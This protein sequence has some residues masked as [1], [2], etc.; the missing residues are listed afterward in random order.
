[1]KKNTQLLHIMILVVCTP[2]FAYAQT[3]SVFDM[4]LDEL[5]KIPVSSTSFLGTSLYQSPGFTQVINMED[6]ARGPARSMEDI[7][8]MHVPGTYIGHHARHGALHGVRG[9]LIDNNAKTAVTLDGQSINQRMHF[10]YTAG[11]TSPLLGDIDRM[12]ITHGPGSLTQGSGAINGYINMVPKNGQDNEGSFYNV[13]HGAMEHAYVMEFG[14]G[15]SYGENKNLFL[16]AGAYNAEG[17]EP[18]N[19]YGLEP[20]SGSIDAYG[21]GEAGYRFSSYWKHNVFSLNAFYYEDNPQSGSALNYGTHG[22]EGYFQQSTF[23]LRPKLDL[24][25]AMDQ[26][27]SVSG[28]LIVAD[29]GFNNSLASAISRGGSE[30]HT[31][32]MAVYKNTTMTNNALAIGASYG[33]K[34][35]RDKN[36]YF[37]SDQSGEFASINTEWTEF[38]IFAEDKYT[39][40]DK[41][42]A[43]L[44]LRYDKYFLNE[45]SK[46]GLPKG[47]SPDIDGHFSPQVAFAYEL[48]PKTIAKVSYRHG[49]RMPDAIYYDSN[50][51]NNVAAEG[52]GFPIHELEPESMDVYEFNLSSQ[53]SETWLIG[54]NLFHN[55]FKDQ[56]SW[57]VLT[58][59]WGDNAAAVGAASGNPYGMFQNLADKEEADGGE[60]MVNWQITPDMDLRGSYSYAK[61]GSSLPQRM[62]VNMVKLDLTGNL[63]ND[64]CHYA[65]NYIF[66]TAMDNVNNPAGEKWHKAYK[67]N[68]N[69]VNMAIAY[70]ITENGS[71]YLRVHNVFE[72]NRPVITFNSSRPYQ[73]T[74]GSDERRIYIGYRATF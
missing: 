7:L 18:D 54:L 68:E 63:F 74:L 33:Y 37:S 20:E 1:M 59:A 29:F 28:A 24:E 45:F 50:G 51:R 19:T 35:F 73:G 14:H 65:L 2:L 46:E 8:K 9:I 40:T 48:L 57:A 13:E 11:M 39:F 6:M 47:V 32:L 44:G 34:K 71:L 70:D 36:Q 17:F 30:L 31:D 53:L 15:F 27:L 58:D 41:L 43:T 10:G 12:E 22:Q 25:L 3:K 26:E 64:K 42:S 16:Y 67:Q 38:S 56:L 69:L 49:Y 66:S 55:E 21:F 4:S 61:V 52:L 60:L 23:G 5:T 72:D 62:P